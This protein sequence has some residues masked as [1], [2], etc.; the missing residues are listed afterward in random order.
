MFTSYTFSAFAPAAKFV[1]SAA[2]LTLLFKDMISQVGT[3][4][5]RRSPA[6]RGFVVKSSPLSPLVSYPLCLSMGNS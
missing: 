1:N 2:D 4:R 3:G 6:R 5:L